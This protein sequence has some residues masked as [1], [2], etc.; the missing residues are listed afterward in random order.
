MPGLQNTELLVMVL[1]NKIQKNKEAST[2]R[3][4]NDVINNYM[5]C[6]YT[7]YY[8][9][10]NIGYKYIFTV[11]RNYTYKNTLKMEII[12]NISNHRN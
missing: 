8:L 11:I 6:T 10:A 2:V 9:C 12:K 7:N 3:W 5:L 1:S 4:V